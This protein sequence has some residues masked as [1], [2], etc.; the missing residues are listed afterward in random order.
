MF[1]RTPDP[2]NMA[3]WRPRANAPL[4]RQSPCLDASMP[5][6]IRALMPSSLRAFTVPSWYDLEKGSP[7]AVGV[8][9][10]CLRNEMTP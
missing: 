4:N 5:S 3:A 6:S 2:A 8:I 7:V 1:M 10:P 9:G